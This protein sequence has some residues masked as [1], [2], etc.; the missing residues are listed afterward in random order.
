MKSYISGW[1][2]RLFGST[3]F[4]DIQNGILFHYFMKVMIANKAFE[5]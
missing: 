1:N 5:M 4:A 3:F 2:G